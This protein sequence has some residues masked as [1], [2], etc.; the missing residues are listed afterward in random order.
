[1]GWVGAGAG[2]VMLLVYGFSMM[3]RG[4]RTQNDRDEIIGLLCVLFCVLIVVLGLTGKL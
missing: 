2:F 4:Y 3:K 1:M